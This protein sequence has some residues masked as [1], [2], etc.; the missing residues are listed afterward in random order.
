MWKIY[1]DPTTRYRVAL[2]SGKT[3]T[4]SNPK[5]VTEM[6]SNFTNIFAGLVLFNYH[7]DDVGGA[8]GSR[9]SLTKEVLCVV[10]GLTDQ[11]CSRLP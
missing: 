11:A 7:L 6:E 3:R 1:V 9:S 4:V 8:C 10:T 2:S 5:V